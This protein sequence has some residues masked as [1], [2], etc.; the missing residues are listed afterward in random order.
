MRTMMMMMKMM[1]LITL[2]LT[3]LSYNLLFIITEEKKHA[4]V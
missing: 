2:E 4:N 1:I 3:H